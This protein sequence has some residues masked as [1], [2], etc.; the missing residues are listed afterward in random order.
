MLSLTDSMLK[1]NVPAEQQLLPL[2]RML[3][4]NEITQAVK[5]EGEKKLLLLSSQPKAETVL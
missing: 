3:Q 2:G 4:V 1:K 5:R